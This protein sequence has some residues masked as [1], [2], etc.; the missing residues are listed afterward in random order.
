ML[1]RFQKRLLVDNRAARGVDEIGGRLHAGEIVAPDEAARALAQDHMDGDDI[2]ARKQLLLGGVAD[3]RLLA[4]FR[5][6]V[7]APGDH[8]HAERFGDARDLAAELAQTHHAQRPALDLDAR[9]GLPGL[10][11]MHPRVLPSDAAGQFQDQAHGQRRG[12]VLAPLRAADHN[13][14]LLGRFH[15]DGGIAHA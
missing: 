9:K 8:L 6:K 13:A 5:R 14:P 1:Q 11:R 7:R 15:V 4:A 10:A 3:T 12:R 2:G